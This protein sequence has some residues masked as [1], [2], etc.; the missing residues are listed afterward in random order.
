MIKIHYNGVQYYYTTE[1]G[2]QIS[3]GYKTVAR[4]KHYAGLIT[5]TTP[6]P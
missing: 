5:T 4:L 2:V 1:K 3:K 6:L